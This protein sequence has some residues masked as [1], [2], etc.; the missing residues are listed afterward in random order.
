MYLVLKTFFP[1]YD[2][3]QFHTGLFQRKLSFLLKKTEFLSRLTLLL[4][5]DFSLPITSL[6]KASEHNYFKDVKSGYW[7]YWAKGSISGLLRKWLHTG[8][9]GQDVPCKR[10]DKQSGILRISG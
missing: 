2:M 6:Y 9:P 4:L 1:P 3:N 5:T 7:G 8:L 10:S